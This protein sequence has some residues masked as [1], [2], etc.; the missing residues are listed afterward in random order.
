LGGGLEREKA[1]K[2]R[3]RNLSVL[4]AEEIEYGLGLTLS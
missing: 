1:M 2:T 3:E 4:L